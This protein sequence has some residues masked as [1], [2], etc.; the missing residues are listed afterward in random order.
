MTDPMLHMICGKIA[1][2][3]STLAAQL[4]RADRT[5]LIAEDDWLGALFSDQMSSGQDYLRYS[6]R[7]QSVMAP[8]V[9]ALLQAGL[10]VVLDFP[11]NTPQQRGWMRA[12]LQQTE[13]EHQMHLLDASDA[14]CLARLK[15]RNAAGT[16]PFTVTEAQFHR[17]TSHFAPPDPEEG[18]AVIR[19]Q[20]AD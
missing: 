19:H 18:F 8:H 6:A 9:A 1:A 7:L 17:F 4:A 10:S 13:A 5:V 16:H 2:G 3:K 14:T 15:A 11:A 12:L 20:V